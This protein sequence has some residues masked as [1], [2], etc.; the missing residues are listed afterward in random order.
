MVYEF[1][2]GQGASKGLTKKSKS[3]KHS[4]TKYRN[5]KKA[6]NNQKPPTDFNQ[7]ILNDYEL[8]ENTTAL[9]TRNNSPTLHSN[10]NKES[11][12]EIPPQPLG[13][14]TNMMNRGDYSPINVHCISYI[15]VAC[16]YATG[17][18]TGFKKFDFIVKD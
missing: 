15:D 12:E 13:F 3:K 6:T 2:H 17:S 11:I 18:S 8:D 1:G 14:L 9:N 7:L 5:Q 16:C 10:E 4:F